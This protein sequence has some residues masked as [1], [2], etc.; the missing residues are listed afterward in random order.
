MTADLVSRV[1]FFQTRSGI[2]GNL[3]LPLKSIL[4]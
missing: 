2:K 4:H 3:I 1:M